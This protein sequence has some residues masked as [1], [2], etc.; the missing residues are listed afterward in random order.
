[1]VLQISKNRRLLKQY[2][3][4][5]WVGVSLG[6]FWGA[7]LAKTVLLYYLGIPLIL[8]LGILGIYEFRIKKKIYTIREVNTENKEKIQYCV[9]AIENG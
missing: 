1:M 7:F 3:I 5:L 4:S 9:T 2:W 6:S 8:F